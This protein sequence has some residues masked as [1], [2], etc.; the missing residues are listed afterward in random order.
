MIAI[1]FLLMQVVP[2]GDITVPAETSAI[3]QASSSGSMDFDS[4]YRY[5]ATLLVKFN[6]EKESAR[7]VFI[8]SGEPAIEYLVKNFDSKSASEMSALEEMLKRMGKP[9][10]D[11]ILSNIDYRGSDEEARALRLS[12]RIISE[13]FKY[14][15][16]LT[17]DDVVLKVAKFAQDADWRVRGAAATTLGY[18]RS[19]KGLRYLV[20]AAKDT[21]SL[22]RKSGAYGIRNLAQA[23][24]IPLLLTLLGDDYYGVRFAASEGLVK[25][26]AGAVDSIAARLRFA[27]DPQLKSLM[28]RTLGGIKTKKSMQVMKSF[29]R[30]PSPLVR[31]AVYEGVS[32]TRLLQKFA[33]TETDLVLVN[34]LKAKTE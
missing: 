8:G 32:D 9:A 27:G 10:I 29:H 28:I 21:I 24:D 1:I 33:E 25:I 12:L 26:G 19:R 6:T 14:D 22:V 30:D 7:K 11:G 4:L 3:S 15:S 17:G 23:E 5:A 13:T 18:S 34:Y 2:A 16:T 20:A 31:L